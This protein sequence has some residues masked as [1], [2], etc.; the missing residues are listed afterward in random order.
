MNILIITKLSDIM[1][2]TF[3]KPLINSKKV[4]KL[5]VIRDSKSSISYKN[6]IFITTFPLYK[7]K[8]LRHLGKI[9]KGVHICKNQKI[10]LIIGILIY[11]HGYIASLISKIVNI[12]FIHISIA[13]HREFWLFGSCVEKLNTFLFKKALFITTT[14]QKSKD[15]LIKKGFERDKVI[16]LPNIIEMNNYY[17]MGLEKQ[18]DIVSLSRLDKNKN[19]T[20]LIQA[21]AKLRKK[22]NVKVIIG[23][24]GP[25]LENLKQEV[26]KLQLENNINFLGW[27]EQ[28]DIL[29]IYNSS[30]IFV[31]PSLGEGFPLTIL[32]AMAC[33]CVPVVTNVGDISEIVKDGYNGSIIYDPNHVDELAVKL[34]TLLVDN[35]KINELSLNAKNIKNNISADINSNIWNNVLTKF[36]IK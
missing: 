12:S 18:Y 24:I 11:P 25:E 6:V 33:G 21:V 30:K 28:V 19:I 35:K 5:F 20:I 32:E 29:N 2:D 27:V 3:L 7:L 17:D 26:K 8:K 31:L 22:I 16:V 13:G 10:D 15:Y 14:G 34:S 36:E 4:N 1:L 9:L 23:G